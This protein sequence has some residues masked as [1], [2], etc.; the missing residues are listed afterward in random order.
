M[1]IWGKSTAVFVP[2]GPDTV[3]TIYVDSC[4]AAEIQGL[5]DQGVKTVAS[6]C[7]HGDGRPNALVSDD[8]GQ[9]ARCKSLGYTP[10]SFDNRKDVFLIVLKGASND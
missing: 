3:R 8:D 9:A 4:I 2:N 10:E 5:I 1:C 7:M 6:C